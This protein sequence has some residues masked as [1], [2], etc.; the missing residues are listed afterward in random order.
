MNARAPLLLLLLV[1][2]AGC[3]TTHATS[4]AELAI[5][6]DALANLPRYVQ[7]PDGA[8]V[9]DKTPLM[10]GVYGHSDIHKTLLATVD[11]KVINGRRV[12]VRRFH[13]PQVPNCHVLFI[14][15]SERYR[16]PWIMK[17]V[18]H[19]TTLTVSEFD[20]FLTLGGI[21]RMSVK[22]DKVRFHVNTTTA[23][24]VGLHFSS[25]FLSVADQVV[26]EP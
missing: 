22:D 23:K 11:G 4:D 12:M 6:T 15:Q 19:S 20:D 3:V 26:G 18:E 14:A 21:L 2:L 25:K 10:L 16:V 17:K 13:W 9:I 8:F 7:W 1:S 24:D 5:K